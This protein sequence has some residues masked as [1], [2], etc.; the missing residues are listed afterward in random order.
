LRTKREDGFD[1]YG[2]DNVNDDD[3]E[4]LVS[5]FELLV[6]SFLYFRIR[7]DRKS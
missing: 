6:Y 5:P 2:E 1:G 7:N 4:K 3:D